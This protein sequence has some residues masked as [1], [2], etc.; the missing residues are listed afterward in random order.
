ML[1]LLLLLLLCKQLL[2]LMWIQMRQCVLA[3]SNPRYTW[4][5]ATLHHSA[6]HRSRLA[7]LWP[8][9]WMYL[10]THRHSRLLSH[11]YT[12]IRWVSMNHWL[13][14][15]SNARVAAHAR[16]CRKWLCHGHLCHILNTRRVPICDNRRICSKAYGSFASGKSGE[17][18][19][20]N[21]VRTG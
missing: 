4:R 10:G 6:H 20:T 5:P 2:I 15:M 16:V 3:R 11:G 19:H 9:L 21:T 12:L 18:S 8:S 17:P 1:H 7:N 14:S 13:T